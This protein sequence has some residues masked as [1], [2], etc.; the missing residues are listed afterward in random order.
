M[1]ASLNSLEGVDLN[2]LECI[3]SPAKRRGPV[4]GRT[5][6]TR[7]SASQM[8]SEEQ[9]PEPQDGNYPL[10]QE[11]QIRQMMQMNQN[12]AQLALQQVGLVGAADQGAASFGANTVS[13]GFDPSAAAAAAAQ[14]QALQ[15]QLNLL[16]QLQAQQK[17]AGGD[18]SVN[19]NL[20]G[21]ALGP[22]NTIG[23]LSAG[24][25]GA[26]M[27]DDDLDSGR[28]I[29]SAQPS[30]RQ[31]VDP[32]MDAA[33]GVPPTVAAHTRLLQRNDPVGSRLR[34]Y[35]RL[36]VDEL[37]SLPPI[38]TDEEYC[39]RLNLPGISTRLIPGTHL[40]ALSAA[41]FAEVAIGALVHNDVTLAL[42]LCNAVVHCLRESVQEPVQPSYMYEVARSY[43]LLGVFR[44]FRGDM[45]RYF[46]YRRVCLTYL[47][48]LNVSV[49]IAG[50]SE[51]SC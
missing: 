41:R 36:S 16:Q 35:Y 11:F 47:S 15:Q 19:G 8:G 43:F 45:E 27:M 6:P 9:S 21:G 32:V 1:T 30:R 5:G 18:G 23:A 39:I 48:K 37:F 34:A 12:A 29:A 28:Q 7:K 51:S 31:R 13:S 22:N 33:E 46:K 42:E 2:D 20:G 4:P 26:V 10:E 3:Y 50:L 40:A 44:A 49:M 25:G 17:L 38:P 14:H 24:G